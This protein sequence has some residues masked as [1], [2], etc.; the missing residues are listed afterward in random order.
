MGHFNSHLGL[1]KEIVHQLGIVQDS[2]QLPPIELW[3][4]N[5]LKKH[6][7]ALASLIHTVA[8]LRS[9]IGWLKYGDA[10]T[11]LFHLHAHNRKRMN[12]IARL[13]TED[14][15]ATSHDD[16]AEV[17]LDFYSDLI[18][19]REQRERTIDLDALGIQRHNLDTLD[20]SISEE[21]AWNTIKQLPSDKASGPDGFTGRF[22]KTCWQT[23]KGDIMSAMS[24]V[25][26]RDFR[27]FRLLNTTL[28]TLLPK[29]EGVAHA[30]D[31]R[32]ISLI[33]SFA[34]LVMKIL[35]NRLAAR[36]DNMVSNNQ[37]A[38]IKGRFIQ[39][40]F[41]FVQLSPC[42]KNSRELCSNW[43]SQRPSTPCRGP[44]LWRC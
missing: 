14:R 10:N 11:G 2:R 16:K 42:P 6:S 35:A 31:F 26:R 12:F 24:S 25:W 41:M 39:D 19:S 1:A 37:S 27:N 18:G 7:L 23:I 3:L 34:K 20:A 8:R 40:N 21:G 30:K 29:K 36:L 44:F 22:Y 38:F 9:R 17:L 4:R 5:S 43:I 33:H 13:T 32:P 15:I 28:V